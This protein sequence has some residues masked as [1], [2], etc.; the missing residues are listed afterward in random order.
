VS[1]QVPEGHDWAGKYM[2]VGKPTDVGIPATMSQ[3]TLGCWITSR[4]AWIRSIRAFTN[5][6][7]RRPAERREGPDEKTKIGKHGKGQVQHVC[8]GWDSR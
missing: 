7:G 6:E 1:Q 4:S 3:Q 8:P 2:M 5:A